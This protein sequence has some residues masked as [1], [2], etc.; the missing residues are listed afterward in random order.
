M[1]RLALLL[2]ACAF[3]AFGQAGTISG[4]V[5]AEGSRK[6]LEASLTIVSASNGLRLQTVRS[7][8]QGAF[9]L[10]APVGKVS[11]LARADGFA[12]EQVDVMVRPGRGNAD[13]SIT[14][15]PAGS[16]SGRVVDSSGNAVRGARVW[17][18]YRGEGNAWRSSDEAG[19]EETDAS[20]FFEVPV[21][22]Q[23]KP[24]LLHAEADGWLLSTSETMFLRTP[25]LPEVL[26]LLSR[27]GVTIGGRILDSAGRPVADAD[28]QLRALPANHVF[29]AEQRHSMAFAR[30][31][32]RSV[33][34]RSDGSYT[35]TGVPTG[36]VVISARTL[37]LRGNVDAEV[38][39]NLH[40]DLTVR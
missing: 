26:L 5:L 11:I 6:P 25:A 19:G 3:I 7:N 10:E 37:D 4:Q 15:T 13:V 31:M 16:V 38:A 21:V 34:T 33:R 30:T 28:V 23:R 8:E 32:T 14:L 27:R 2:V 36:R 20:G 1:M 40:V 29:S 12:S 24:F 9:T 35:F 17:L 22:A 39:S 18:Q